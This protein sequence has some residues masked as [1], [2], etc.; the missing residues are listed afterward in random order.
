MAASYYTPRF[1]KE[2]KGTFFQAMVHL[3]QT[4]LRLQEKLSQGLES[5]QAAGGR[6]CLLQASTALQA[7]VCPFLVLN[8][9]TDIS[10]QEGETSS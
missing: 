9:S 6:S 4:W 2:A 7:A 3:K 8:V 1:A 10:N 5:P